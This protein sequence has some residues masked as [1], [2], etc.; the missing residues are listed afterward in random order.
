MFNDKIFFSPNQNSENL[1]L[2][3][4]IEWRLES[5]VRE[6]TINRIIFRI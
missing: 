1:E 3:V 6:E 2:L 5:D 4:F